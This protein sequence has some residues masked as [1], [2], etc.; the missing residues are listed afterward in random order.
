MALGGQ[1]KLTPL[2]DAIKSCQTNVTK[3]LI[4]HILE[5]GN[6]DL[7]KSL[8]VRKTKS[9]KNLFELA[10]ETQ[11]KT[12]IKLVEKFIVAANSGNHET[13]AIMKKLNYEK[14]TDTIKT[15]QQDTTKSFDDDMHLYL[16]VS[17]IYFYKYTATYRLHFTKLIMNTI[18]SEKRSIIETRKS[19]SFVNINRKHE[20]ELSDKRDNNQN[21]LLAEFSFNR[22]A[23]T[24]ATDIRTFWKLCKSNPSGNPAL[25]SVELQ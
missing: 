21:T 3:R 22:S 11:N 19:D 5:T 16:A 23:D 20:I 4:D 15:N 8:I 13:C 2:A 18:R 25:L 7:I 10:K 1:D 9:G 17:S 24:M 6:G 14:R 12:I